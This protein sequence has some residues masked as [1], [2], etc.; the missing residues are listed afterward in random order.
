MKG[1]AAAYG[2]GV[3]G[4]ALLRR[5]LLEAGSTDERLVEDDGSVFVL[6]TCRN[7]LG[8]PLRWVSGPAHTFRVGLPELR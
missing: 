3:V 8:C 7:A 4:H 1:R 5:E 6:S 2:G